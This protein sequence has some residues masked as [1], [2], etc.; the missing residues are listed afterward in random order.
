MSRS[1]GHQEHLVDVEDPIID[2]NDGIFHRQ[3]RSAWKAILKTVDLGR[4]A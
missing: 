2:L 3:P 4:G 1:P